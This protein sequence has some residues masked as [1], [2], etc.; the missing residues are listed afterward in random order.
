MQG[1]WDLGYAW[2]RQEP[3]QHH[4]AMPG[5]VLLS[6][7]TTALMWGWVSFAGCLALGWGSLLRPG[8]IFNMQRRNLLFPSDCGFS[9]NYCLV[10]LMEP[11]TRFTAARHQCTRL[12]I[13]DLLQVATLAFE[14]MDVNCYIWPYSPQTFLNRFKAVL[15]SIGLPTSPTPSLKA[16]DPG[17]L[18]AGGASWLMQV[19]D[20]GDIVRRRGR[21]QNARIMEVYV[22][23]V[24]SL[25]YLQ[26]L[27]SKVKSMVFDL[28]A[29]F[30]AV[31]ERALSLQAAKIPYH[32][33]YVLFSRW[34][35]P[36]ANGKVT[37]ENSMLLGSIWLSPLQHLQDERAPCV[38]QPLTKLCQI[39]I[40][41]VEKKG[42]WIGDSTNDCILDFLL[43]VPSLCC[44]WPSHITGENSMLLGSIW[45]SP[46]Q[47]L[48]DERAPCVSQ[49]L[50]KLCQ[51]QIHWVEKK[52]A[53]I[54][55]YIYALYLACCIYLVRVQLEGGSEA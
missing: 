1:A 34:K 36:W 8:E 49:P 7:I 20:S 54:G 5:V 9:V 33:W 47:H 26:F 27:D 29:H 12:D 45:L 40:H 16:L 35:M 23:E 44:G 31:L 41:W 39:Q 13:P 17:S 30:T 14:K 18:R 3:S 32:I 24:S 53:W 4:L 25:I 37:G 2:M 11:K 22:Q 52:G 50:T 10:S 46:L 15:T 21:W 48:Q 55:I 42:A 6:M 51:I 28:A 19:T 43:K 38:S